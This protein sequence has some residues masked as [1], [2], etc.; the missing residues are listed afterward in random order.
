MRWLALPLL[1]VTAAAC[2]T[3]STG[4][5][6][7]LEDGST[8]VLQMEFSRWGGTMTGTHP[9]TGER[10]AGDYTATQGRAAGIA[11]GTAVYVENYS[12]YGAGVLVGDKGTVLDCQL[13]INAGRPPRGNGTCTDQHG[14]RY[15]LQF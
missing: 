7:S 15:R 13:N 5:L 3:K 9:I 4:R 8:I 2:A 10:F 12:A 14:R 6:V 11:G 1:V